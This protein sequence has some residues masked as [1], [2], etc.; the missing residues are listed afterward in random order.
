MPAIMPKARLE[1]EPHGHPALVRRLGHLFGRKLG[2]DL[3]D[4]LT[5]ALSSPAESILDVLADIDLDAVAC[6]C[7]PLWA[8]PVADR[9]A[10]ADLCQHP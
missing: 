3:P 2:V 4:V 5:L 10:V 8:I 7:V 1:M 9:Q 6:L